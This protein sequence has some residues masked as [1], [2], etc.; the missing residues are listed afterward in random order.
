MH[1]QLT[2]VGLP[3]Y[4]FLFLILIFQRECEWGVQGQRERESASMLSRAQSHE[5]ETMT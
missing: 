3:F 1:R 5:S 2:D 4:L